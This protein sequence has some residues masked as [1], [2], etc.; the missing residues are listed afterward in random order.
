[1]QQTGLNRNTID[2][3]YTCT[4]VVKQCITSIK[5]NILIDKNDIVIEPS[6]GNGAFIK[7]IKKICPNYK[8]YDIEPEHEEIT[9][10]DFLELD[11]KKIQKKYENIHIIGNPPFG[12]QASLAIKFI[13][14]CCEFAKTIS[15]ILPKSFK[16]ES[17]KKHFAL[18]YHMLY[19]MDL[20]TNSFL[21]NDAECDV[22]CVFQIWEYKNEFR[23]CAEK[24]TPI[25]F[26]FVKKE[27][28]PDISVRRVGVYAGDISKNIENKSIQS[29]YFIKFTNNK[30]IEK[31]IKKLKN[32]KFE[33]DNTVGPK[34]ISKP[35][36][37]AEFNRLL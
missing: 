15:F 6:A 35:E 13:K 5:D 20:D 29:H 2:K 9:Q 11:Y 19:E 7:R 25:S 16:K 26:I 4:T 23:I 8:F 34:S 3:Y 12:R 31:N 21:V 27:N 24:E 1:M 18:N 14:K 28:N 30:S 17:M 37:I 32:I 22:P 33:T 10:K 36:L